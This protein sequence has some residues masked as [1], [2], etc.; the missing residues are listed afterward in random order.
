M[1]LLQ[2]LYFQKS[3][4]EKIL[5][6][7]ALFSVSLSFTRV[8]YT[9]ELLFLS[10]IWNLFLAFVP[11]A[12]SKSLL[13]NIPWIEN[14]K[15]FIIVCITWLLF[16]P[17]SFYIITDLFHLEKRPDVP[18]WFDLA[19]IFSFAWNGLLLGVLS[20]RQMEKAMEAKF[21]LRN[22]W[23]F[24]LPVMWLNAFGIYLGRYLRYNSWD[25]IS[26]PFSLTED[27]LYLLVH[28]IR[29]RFDWSMI[30][31]YAVLMSII[32]LSIKKLSITKSE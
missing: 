1:A 11:Y 23:L 3:E 18:Q 29:N 13:Q 32:Y 17:N 16:I 28:P 6:L 14:N 21:Q 15:K 5:L 30:F 31:C 26:N 22:E 25:V 20:V 4:V 8:L 9:G 27:I 24:V 10:L 12:I 2:R 7:S 19:L